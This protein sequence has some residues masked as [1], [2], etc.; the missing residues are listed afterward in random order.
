MQ[1]NPKV[2]IVHG[3][4]SDIEK[5]LDPE[6]RTYDKHWQPWL[7]KELIQKRYSVVRPLMPEPWAPNYNAFRK[8]FEKNEIPDDAILIGHSC[9]AAF[10]VRWLGD[11]KHGATKLILVAPWK[12]PD[13]GDVGK[14]EYYGYEIDFKAE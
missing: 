7:E 2:F 4:P 6:R 9:G 3:C 12:I 11:T 14:E 5:A 1:I 10:L 8:E 13:K